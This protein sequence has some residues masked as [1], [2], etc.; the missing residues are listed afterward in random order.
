VLRLL[1]S[2][3]FR[4]PT[5]DFLDSKIWSDQQVGLAQRPGPSIHQW[6][7]L[8]PQVASRAGWVVFVECTTLVALLSIRWRRIEHRAVLNLITESRS[9]LLVIQPRLVHRR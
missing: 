3:R 8:L 1:P 9:S 2:H 6:L 4:S 7:S 5:H